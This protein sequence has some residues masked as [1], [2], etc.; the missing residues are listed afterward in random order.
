VPR[1]GVVAG[2]E[3]RFMRNR[4]VAHRGKIENGRVGGDP[5]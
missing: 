2:K 1:L 5:G 3:S 4:Q